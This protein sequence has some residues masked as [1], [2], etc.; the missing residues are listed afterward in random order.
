VFENIRFRDRLFSEYV[1]L[2]SH[3]SDLVV[4]GNDQSALAMFEVDG[5]PPETT[6]PETVNQ[7]HSR[8]NVTWQNI[9]GCRRAL[10]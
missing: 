8:L 2:V 4:S 1:P 3:I 6:E 5:L 7:W 9:A 10:C